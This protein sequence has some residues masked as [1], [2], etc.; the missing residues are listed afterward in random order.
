MKRTALAFLLSVI[1]SPSAHAGSWFQFE[2]GIGAARI[3][4]LGDGVWIQQGAPNNYE[5]RDTPAFLVGMTGSLYARDAFDLRWHADYAYIGEY[6]ASVD[7]VPD[8]F[9]DPVHHEVLPAWAQTG[10]RYSPFNGHGHLQGVPVTLDVGYTWNGWRF[11]VEAGP[12]LYWQTWH[13]SLYGLDSEWHDLS[14]KT[15][16][17]VNYVIGASIE[18]ENFVLSYRYYNAPQSWNPYPGL[19]RGANVVM[20][21]CRF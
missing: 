2:A 4:D 11:G 8:E 12:W 17:Q 1:F 21:Q 13:E 20:M 3:N 7:G 5:Q 6:A 14:H 9:Y 10:A 18:R 19:A 16:M 15:Q